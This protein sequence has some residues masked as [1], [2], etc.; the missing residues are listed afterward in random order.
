MSPVSVTYIGH[1]PYDF[2][3]YVSLSYHEMENLGVLIML[4]EDEVTE[5]VTALVLMT[6]S[7]IVSG[8][9]VSQ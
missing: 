4:A 5:S 8:K 3:C 9:V 1:F 2:D 7:L 6:A